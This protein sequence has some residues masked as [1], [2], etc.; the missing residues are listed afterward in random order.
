VPIDFRLDGVEETA[1][2]LIA[3]IENC[4]LAIDHNAKI[5]RELTQ[6][7]ERLVELHSGERDPTPAPRPN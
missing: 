3:A 1:L 7:T 2:R 6:V 5:T 4:R